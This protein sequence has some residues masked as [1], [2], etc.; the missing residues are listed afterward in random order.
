[1]EKILDTNN[2]DYLTNKQ[3]KEN[4][5][6]FSAKRPYI[7]YSESIKLKDLSK[8]EIDNNKAQPNDSNQMIKEPIKVGQEDKILNLFKE[9]EKKTIYT[10]EI[11]NYGNSILIGSFCN[12]ITFIAFGVYKT[13]LLQDEYTNIWSLMAL[14]GGLGQMTTG[15]MELIKEREFPSMIYLIYGLYC[16]SHYL[17]RITIDRFGE[18]DLCI[19]YLAFLL[20]SIPIAIYSLKINLIYL[21]QSIATSLYFLFKCIGEGINEY[22]LIEQVAGSFQIISGVLSFY[23]FLSQTINWNNFNFS[24]PTLPFD[25]NNKIDFIRQI[26]GK[27]HNS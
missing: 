11:K 5:N 15:I 18:F 27:E 13:R 8:N 4:N 23:I 2:T 19:Y 7:E 3:V 12:A 14:F 10:R 20:L 1:M 22:I 26:I 6:E 16:L 25:I 24:L 17:L 9:L 21:L